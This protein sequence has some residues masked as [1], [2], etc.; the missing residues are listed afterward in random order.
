MVAI[1]A[2]VAW[3]AAVG[4]AT[5]PVNRGVICVSPVV[6]AVITSPPVVP[7]T[8][9]VAV[10]PVLTGVEPLT[11]V[12]TYACADEAPGAADVWAVDGAVALGAADAADVEP[13]AAG[14]EAPTGAPDTGAATFGAGATVEPVPAGTAVPST[15]APGES[16]LEGEARA[17]GALPAT[18]DGVAM[19]DGPPGTASVCC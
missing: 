1:T 11:Y 5:V 3:A 12:S 19:L 17:S 2:V 10:G 15:T 4:C 6:L 13:A 18:A 8:K 16:A 14:A 7:R 9:W